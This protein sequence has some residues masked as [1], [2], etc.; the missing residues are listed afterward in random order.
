MDDEADA[1][2]A[3][4]AF[5][6]LRA[7]VAALHQAVE[8]HSAPDYALTLGA[9]AKELQAAGARLNAIEA[10]PQMQAKA[11]WVAPGD[12]GPLQAFHLRV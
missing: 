10:S 3:E 2:G 7:E 4:R 8:G 5:E 1:G 6:A 9:I 12:K 11:G